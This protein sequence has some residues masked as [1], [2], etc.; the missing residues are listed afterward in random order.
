LSIPKDDRMYLLVNFKF[1]KNVVKVMDQLVKSGLYKTRVDV[2]LAAL[3]NYK[4]FV[5]FWEK[6]M[7]TIYQSKNVN[8]R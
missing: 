6:E 4:P 5:T 3:R 8:T 7:D 1:H 2:M